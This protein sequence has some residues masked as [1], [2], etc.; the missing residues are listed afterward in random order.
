M[1]KPSRLI[2][3]KFVGF[4]YIN[5]Q[6]VGKT[7]ANLY[8][9]YRNK[10]RKLEGLILPAGAPIPNGAIA[11]EWSKDSTVTEDKLSAD[12]KREIASKGYRYFKLDISISTRFDESP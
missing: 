10:A 9:R 1:F 2:L 6:N 5:R 8:D 7:V 3:P 11:S 4:G 12:D